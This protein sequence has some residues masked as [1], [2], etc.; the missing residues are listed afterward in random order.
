MFRVGRPLGAFSGNVTRGKGDRQF[1]GACDGANTTSPGAQFRRSRPFVLQDA[2]HDGEN[3]SCDWQMLGLASLFGIAE[4]R[5]GRVRI[6]F[7][8]T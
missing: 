7:S 1:P 5:T 8:G 4:R 6:P 3:Q 2:M